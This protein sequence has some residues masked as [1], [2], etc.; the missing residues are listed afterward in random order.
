[1]YLSRIVIPARE[2]HAKSF[3]S[4]IYGIHSAIMSAFPNPNG[5][6]VLYRMEDTDTD[7]LQNVQILIQSILPPIWRHDKF[8]Q[9]SSFES[10]N[11]E[12]VPRAGEMFRF[13]LRANPTMPKNGKRICINGIEALHRWLH[14]KA[15]ISGFKIAELTMKDEGVVKV[16]KRVLGD[17]HDIVLRSVVFNGVLT[18]DNAEAMKQAL[19]SGIG[20]AKGF[21]FGLLSLAK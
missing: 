11:L 6:R 14:N 12:M 15:A 16:E 21:G 19:R 7:R 17:S 5:N 2:M 20:R 10:R 13:R 3:C 9:G 1:M 8:P 18:V 4:N